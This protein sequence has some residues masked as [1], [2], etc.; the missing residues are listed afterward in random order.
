MVHGASI[1]L[2]LVRCLRAVS[3]PLRLQLLEV[4]GRCLRPKMLALARERTEEAVTYRVR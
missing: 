2:D 3:N 1:E 4:L